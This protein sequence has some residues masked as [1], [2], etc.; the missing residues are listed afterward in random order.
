MTSRR[1]VLKYAAP[2][3]A[4]AATGAQAAPICKTARGSGISRAQYDRYIALYNAADPRFAG[5]Y[6]E[7]VVMETVPPTVGRSGI[8]AFRHELGAYVRETMTVEYYVGDAT[9][10]AAQ[11]VG[12][13]QCVRDMPVST[14]HG[15][16]GKDVRK[17]QILRQRGM[18]LYGV[19]NNKFKWI[20]ANPPIILQDWS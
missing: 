8:L 6:H 15:L 1:E 19:S 11:V 20:R 4:I 12:Q 3:I 7:D 16:F 5:Y 2:A 10:S 17:G 18:L 14:F 13:F 9:G